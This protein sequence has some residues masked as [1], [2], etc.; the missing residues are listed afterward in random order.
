[1]KTI[2]HIYYL[3]VDYVIVSY[4]SNDNTWH[5]EIFQDINNKINKFGT[6][7]QSDIFD[8]SFGSG[9]FISSIH[10]VMKSDVVQ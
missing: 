3:I 4:M 10:Q 8:F 5:S 6:F 9:T 7:Y 2:K 1:M